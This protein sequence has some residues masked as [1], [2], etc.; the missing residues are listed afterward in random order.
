MSLQSQGL[1]QLV[2]GLILVIGITAQQQ[3]NCLPNQIHLNIGDAYYNVMYDQQGISTNISDTNSAYIVWQTYTFCTNSFVRFISGNNTAQYTDIAPF[4][5]GNFSEETPDLTCIY[6]TTTYVV[7]LY[8]LTYGQNYTYWVY[9]GDNQTYV[10]PFTFRLFSPSNTPTT[11]LYY[12]DV[13][14]FQDGNETLD[15]INALAQTNW[16]SIDGIIHLGDIG[17]NIYSNCSINGEYFFNT[18]QPANNAWPFIVT[19]GNHEAV[20][21]FSFINFR[22]RD[23]LYYYSSNHYFSFNAGYAHYIIINWD[24]YDA[25]T[26]S[27]QTQMLNWVTYDLQMANNVRDIWPWIIVST[28]RPIYCSYNMMQEQPIERCYNFYADRLQWDELWHL[29]KVDLMITG[30][31]HSYERVGPTYQ[32]VSQ[33]NQT[34]WPAYSYDNPNSTI[35]IVNGIAGNAYWINPDYTPLPYSEVVSVNISYG[36]LTIFNKT[37]LLYQQIQS[38]DSVVIDY[39]WL[40]KNP[41]VIPSPAGPITASTSGAIYW[42]MGLLVG[43]VLLTGTF[44][45]MH[46]MQKQK[47]TR[48]T[49]DSDVL[50]TS[51]HEA[52]RVDSTEIN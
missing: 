38:N 32:N 5:V 23:P 20:D 17:Y 27:E 7:K 30:H 9:E 12:G 18:A 3:D 6:N 51:Q 47:N 11:F 29:Y 52:L 26:P 48:I 43:I 16:S 2:I 40:T 45:I 22:L 33:S 13:D 8:N 4:E 1:Y 31:V 15:A 41:P 28:H 36:A 24:F 37:T 14:A 19:P 21:N 39:M 42:I 10:G 50:N 44:A 34:T 46:W 35:Y 49:S 25:A